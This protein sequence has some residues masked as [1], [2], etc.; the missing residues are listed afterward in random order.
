MRLATVCLSIAL[1]ACVPAATTPSVTPVAGVTG[2]DDRL[3]DALDTV[4]DVGASLSPSIVGL[5][6]CVAVLQAP[7]RSDAIDGAARAR[8]GF[9]ACRTRTG[10]SRPAPITLAWENARVP[11]ISGEIILLVM[12]ESA[13]E[14]LLQNARLRLGTD[15]SSAAGVVGTAETDAGSPAEV[16]SY[17]RTAGVLSGLDVGQGTVE[18]NQDAT[19]GLYGGQRDFRA[20]LLGAK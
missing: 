1:M 6:R 12:T 17:G 19:V 16:L 20:L 2:V 7:N 5:T 11:P 10:W 9:V 8:Q 3:D 14:K 13:Q 18:Q 4:S 15:A